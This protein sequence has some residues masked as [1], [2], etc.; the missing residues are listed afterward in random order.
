MET[1][2]VLSIFRLKTTAVLTR[3]SLRFSAIAFS[4]FLM[5]GLGAFLFF[6]EYG[7]Q[8]SDLFSSLTNLHGVFQLF[9]GQLDFQ[10]KELLFLAYNLLFE[11]FQI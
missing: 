8:S 7:F 11:L 3:F 6:L 5:L 9:G 10:V 4:T 1:I 2:A